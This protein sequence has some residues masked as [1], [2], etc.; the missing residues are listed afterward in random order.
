M[1]V[2]YSFLHFQQNVHCKRKHLLF[3]VIYSKFSAET[4][5]WFSFLFFETLH[6]LINALSNKSRIRNNVMYYNNT[7]TVNCKVT[8]NM[9]N[10]NHN[11]ANL[12]AGRSN[13]DREIQ[14]SECV[15]WNGREMS[16][17]LCTPCYHLILKHP[18]YSYA[19]GELNDT[20]YS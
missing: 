14:L 10:P 20:Q 1:I 19:V 13:A 18:L 5:N 16:R 12:G 7:K 2:I 6:S 17:R 15:S 4:Y 8:T 9:R 3:Y 11:R